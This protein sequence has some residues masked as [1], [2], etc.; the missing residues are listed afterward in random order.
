MIQLRDYQQECLV[1][2]DQALADA[3]AAGRLPR[4]LVIAATGTGKTVIFL[5]WLDKLP[6][7][8]RVLIIAHRRELIYQPRDRAAEFCPAVAERMG[9]VMGQE[10]DV[11]AQVIV[12][13]V[14]SLTS[15]DRMARILAH[16]PIDVCILD[17]A[18]HGTASTYLR[19]LDELGPECRVIGFTATPMRTDGDGLRRVFSSC[20]YRFPID[21]AIRRGPSQVRC[22]G[23]LVALDAQ[24]RQGDRGRLGAREPGRPAQGREHPGDR[25]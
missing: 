2:I 21:A 22:A 9:V 14:Q 25:S 6:T 17:E 3:E 1:A 16:G 12:A 13:T 4:T 15:G 24:G 8:A 18:H 5:A 10:D 20:A 7:D 11:G 23:V 19:V